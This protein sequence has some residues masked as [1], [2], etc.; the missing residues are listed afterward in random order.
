M[1]SLHCTCKGRERPQVSVV[2]PTYNYGDHIG[3]AVDS[4]LAQSYGNVEIIVVDDGSNDDTRQRLE[5]YGD[6]IR[7][8]YQTNAGLSSARN[9]GISLSNGELIALLDSDDAFHPEKLRLQV[10][11]MAMHPDV[12][13]VGTDSFSKEPISWPEL[14]IVELDNFAEPVT[15]DQIVIKSRFA[16]SSVLFR[17]ECLKRA[18]WFATELKSVEDRD[19]WIRVASR[20]R[21]ATIHMP[22]TWYRL[23][24]GSMSR[25]ASTMEYYERVVLDK[26]FAMPQLQ[27]RWGLRRKAFGLAA[28]S[29]AYIYL[30][31]GQPA[32]AWRRMIKSFLTW[33]LPIGVPDVRMPFGRTRLLF[34]S[35]MKAWGR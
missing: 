9:R 6:R 29:A 14:P 25:N 5:K 4:V 22:L 7:Y 23:T 15:L 1:K 30:S 8:V 3:N 16:P 34:R 17:R 27:R 35:A 21:I 32:V 12:G 18:G 20:D 26:A 28:Y 31:N 2:V 13:L 19:M 10:L 33:P 24:A 11:F